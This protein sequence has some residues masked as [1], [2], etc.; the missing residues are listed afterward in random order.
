[1]RLLSKLTKAATWH[2]EPVS[3]SYLFI[4]FYKE[5]LLMLSHE[6]DLVINW[7][8]LFNCLPMDHDTFL[9]WAQTPEVFCLGYIS[10]L[11]CICTV[12][13]HCWDAARRLHN[14][15]LLRRT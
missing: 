14:T 9:G 3:D 1:M 6:V 11:G 15:S 4:S 7:V 5:V 10:L 12:A 2:A 8:L 13:W